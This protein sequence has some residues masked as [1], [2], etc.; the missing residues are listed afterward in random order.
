LPQTIVDF[1]MPYCSNVELANDTVINDSI[2]LNIF[3]NIET[4]SRNFSEWH[5]LFSEMYLYD[6]SFLFS[7][8][9][10]GI[11]EA[12]SLKFTIVGDIVKKGKRE[13]LHEIMDKLPERII[14]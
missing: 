12:A 7:S 2:L 10:F 4:M 14:S 9:V 1:R 11:N 13:K 3:N 6:L 5:R 8:L